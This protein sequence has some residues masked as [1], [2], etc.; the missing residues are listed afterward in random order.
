MNPWAVAALVAGVLPNAPGFAHA[1]GLVAA[2]PQVFVDLYAYTWFVG[3]GLASAVYFVGMKLSDRSSR[4]A[5]T[6]EK[7]H[8]A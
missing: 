1:V 4:A 5:K 7:A 2:V 6:G 3:F 8:G